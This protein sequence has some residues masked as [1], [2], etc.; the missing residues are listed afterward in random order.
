MLT[1][2]EQESILQKFTVPY[3]KKKYT[4][5]QNG[6]KFRTICKECNELLGLNFDLS[7]NEFSLN[8]NK[9]LNSGLVLPSVISSRIQQN[10][11]IKSIYGHLLAAKVDIENTTIDESL[12]AYFFDKVKDMKHNL[13]IFYWIYPYQNIVV[14]RDIIMPAKRGNFKDHAFF[15]I[16]KYFPIAYLVTDKN[17]YE[18]L[19]ELTKYATANIDDEIDLPINLLNIRSIDWPELVDMNNFIVGGQSINSSVFAKPRKLQ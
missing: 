14:V 19:Q 11:I 18:G 4:F 17:N 1:P 9:I 2:V 8:I 7:L 6:V 3:D 12:R 16:L 5:S 13:K 15:S 10:K